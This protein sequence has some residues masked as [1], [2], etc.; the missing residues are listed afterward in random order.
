MQNKNFSQE[1]FVFEKIKFE[2]S[3]STHF[4][5]H[6]L[7]NEAWNSVQRF[8]L[9]LTVTITL[10]Q[11]LVPELI[12]NYP[13]LNIVENEAPDEKKSRLIL[14]RGRT[15]ENSSSRQI[16]DTLFLIANVEITIISHLR[17]F[18]FLFF[19][20]SFSRH[21][22]RI[23]YGNRYLVRYDGHVHTKTAGVK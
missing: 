17:F 1:S 23:V 5:L 15:R 8:S 11:L 20:I 4:Q 2:P 18:S 19:L 6:F 10:Y 16:K 7:E 14:L 9:V 21:C 13:N 3:S 22:S 12:Q